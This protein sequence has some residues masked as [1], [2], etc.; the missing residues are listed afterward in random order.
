MQ[1]E[2]SSLG[3]VRG[4]RGIRKEYVPK[5]ERHPRITLYDGRGNPTTHRVHQWILL[6]FRRL[7]EYPAFECRHKDG[8]PRNNA[9]VNLIVG[10]KSENTHDAVKHGTHPQSRKKLC[11][12]RHLLSGPNLYITPEGRRACRECRRAAERRWRMRQ[13]EG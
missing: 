8:N 7:P 3:R 11:P 2:A 10:T 6:A 12:Q 1:Y 13:Q 4:P 5:G 9:L